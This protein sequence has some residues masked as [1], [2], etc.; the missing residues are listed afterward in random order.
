MS[1]KEPQIFKPVIFMGPLTETVTYPA[2]GTFFKV[3]ID[4]QY[5]PNN[6]EHEQALNT[7]IRDLHMFG[8]KE[9]KM[10]QESVTERV[11]CFG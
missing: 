6:P 11:R 9:K 2:T 10:F 1:N 5:D 7:F 4:I 8:E 3:S